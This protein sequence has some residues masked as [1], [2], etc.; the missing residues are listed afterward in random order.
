VHTDLIGDQQPWGLQQ[1]PEIRALPRTL[2]L[3]LGPKPVAALRYAATLGLLSPDQILYG[4][5]HPSGANAERVNFFLGLKAKAALSRQTRPELLE[6]G[7]EALI[8]QV[9]RLRSRT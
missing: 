9:A 8:A 4:M 7:R 5:P 3:P 1:S 2:W 6:A